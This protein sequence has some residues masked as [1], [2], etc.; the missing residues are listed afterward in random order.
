MPGHDL[1][2]M[3]FLDTVGAVLACKAGADLTQVFVK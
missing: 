2:T 1:A 3:Y